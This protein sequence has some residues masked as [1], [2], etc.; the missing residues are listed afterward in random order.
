[1]IA[2]LLLVALTAALLS[3]CAGVLD[4]CDKGLPDGPPGASK[5]R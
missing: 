4:N 2:R 3:G 5:P 1:V